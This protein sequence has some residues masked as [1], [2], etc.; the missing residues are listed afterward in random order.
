MTNI[1]TPK[2]V[3]DKLTA[4]SSELAIKLS[5]SINDQINLAR[6][7]PFEVTITDY[8][9]KYPRITIDAV[10]D[11][12]RSAGWFIQQGDTQT[13]TFDQ[14]G[15]IKYQITK[16]VFSDVRAKCPSDPFDR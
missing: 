15:E 10:L 5:K 9:D 12:F 4:E 14:R 6:S 3:R 7:L 16:Y 8:P 13:N 1:T 2:Q 11:R